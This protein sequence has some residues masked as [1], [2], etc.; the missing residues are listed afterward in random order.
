MM[1][2]GSALYEPFQMKNMIHGIHG[3]SKRATPFTHGNPV[4]GTFDMKGKLL[5][6]GSWGDDKSAD[7]YNSGSSGAKTTM[8]QVLIKGGTV[9]ANETFATIATLMTNAA[10]NDARATG[11]TIA[12][13]FSAAENYGA[14]VA[15]PGVGI[16]CNACHESNSYKQDLGP[17][18]T[19][20]MKPTTTAGTTLAAPAYEANPNLWNVISPKAATCTGCHNGLTKS[21]TSVIGHV[22]SS[23]AGATFG[24]AT[25]TA[26]AALPRETCD[27][28]HASGGVK[29]VDL[30]HGQK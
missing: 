12:S 23:F 27:D 7:F 10:A 11:K 29:G 9:P 22:T 1:T 15:W 4:V 17:V 30:V 21:G 20:A 8:Y 18:S 24:T 13:T 2:N 25:R 26:V 28:C 16:N 3:N 19:L 14:E 5:T 6:S